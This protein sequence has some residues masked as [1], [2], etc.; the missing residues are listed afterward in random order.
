MKNEIKQ[1]GILKL[2]SC[3]N[4]DTTGSDVPDLTQPNPLSET[5]R[6]RS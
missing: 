4:E 3:Y 5:S 2:A 6:V 1:I